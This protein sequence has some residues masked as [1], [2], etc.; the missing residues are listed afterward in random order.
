M[1]QSTA[2]EPRALRP[3]ADGIPHLV[4]RFPQW[5]HDAL[6][7]V[8]SWVDV[9][10]QMHAAGADALVILTA[11]IPGASTLAAD[12]LRTEVARTYRGL[13]RWLSASGHAPIRFWNYIPGIGD[14]MGA[15]LDRYMV[16]NAGR[17]D[18]FDRGL[19]PAGESFA[20]AVA[21]ASAV[22]IG[23]TDL[24]IHCLASDAPGVAV[25]NPRQTSS[26][27]YSRRF[28]PMPPCF[29]RAVVARVSGRLAL[30]IAG[31]ASIVGEESRHPG[32]MVA[33]LD[34]TLDNIRAIVDAAPRAADMA[35]GDALARLVDLRAYVTTDDVAY[36]VRQ[37]LA[38]C[39]PRAR[40]IDVL[41][42]HV[43]RPELLL[44]IEGVASV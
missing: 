6:G 26:W 5:V 8:P 32:D 34:E 9:G 23:G 22:G 18:A 7:V 29:A 41:R 38:A 21:T 31:T 37:R 42:A 24:V 20:G 15:D 3:Q 43:C 14:P 36:H 33:Q 28:G 12:G 16:F 25:E 39:C 40:R 1:S 30:L 11:T 10:P 19:H 2:S 4:P 44:E 17:Y 13:R 35:D 27:R